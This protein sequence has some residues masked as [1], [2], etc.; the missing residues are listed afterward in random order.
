M[1][2]F[3]RFFLVQETV[4][5]LATMV[6][7]CP[8][9]EDHD[10][11][12]PWTEDEFI[13][14]LPPEDQKRIRRA[15]SRE[16]DAVKNGTA[17]PLDKKMPPI[18]IKGQP[19]VEEFF[20]W[21]EKEKA[22]AA[23]I[24]QA[25]VVSSTPISAIRP[26]L[27]E[28]SS[29]VYRLEDVYSA[30]ASLYSFRYVQGQNK[31]YNTMP[32]SGRMMLGKLIEAEVVKG[33]NAVGDYN[34]QLSTVEE[35]KKG[36]DAWIT[37]PL[38]GTGKKG[39]QLKF[40]SSSSSSALLEMAIVD[41]DLFR[42]MKQIQEMKERVPKRNFL[43]TYLKS[44]IM[45]VPGKGRIPILGKDMYHTTEV[46]ASV[47]PYGLSPGRSPVVR[48]RWMPVLEHI[49]TG[50]VINLL[51]QIE[52][53]KMDEA[54]VASHMKGRPFD[55]ESFDPG[56]FRP[57][58][59]FP[60]DSRDRPTQEQKHIIDRHLTY[61]P[62]GSYADS[63]KRVGVAKVQQDPKDARFIKIIA[64]I[65][66]DI[67]LKSQ[68]LIDDMSGSH[69]MKQYSEEAYKKY[70]KDVTIAPITQNIEDNLNAI[71]QMQIQ[72]VKAKQG[73]RALDIINRIQ[74]GFPLLFERLPNG[75][76]KRK[77]SGAIASHF[78]GRS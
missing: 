67:N 6:T 5:L 74:G 24:T 37:D 54:K 63:S 2:N 15:K 14:S 76:M 3:S 66:P 78:T 42:W 69:P 45:D 32:K 29:D 7:I 4:D 77:S 11:S 72:K 25:R 28:F 57:F 12:K 53:W 59:Y 22:A 58:D 64:N 16:K 23:A 51:H 13:A 61:A 26:D 68:Q 75:D 39:M 49:A 19:T 44:K 17:I 70:D 41:H 65:S 43:D 27:Q 34:I 30:I 31:E 50:L 47:E 48:I 1:L 10:P 56:D 21:L 73:R 8:V 40:K 55:E 35:D 62:P 52:K 18:L 9:N 71:E 38:L 60:R 36:I 33:L 20:P 46:Y